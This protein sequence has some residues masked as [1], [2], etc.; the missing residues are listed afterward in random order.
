MVHRAKV[1]IQLKREGVH[2]WQLK[3]RVFQT[4]FETLLV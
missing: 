3:G 2:L 4:S 1:M